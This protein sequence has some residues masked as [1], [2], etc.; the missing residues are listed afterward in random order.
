MKTAAE[1]G[2]LVRRCQ[3][4]QRAHA[5]ACRNRG[6]PSDR[7]G[8]VKRNARRFRR[9]WREFWKLAGDGKLAV[10]TL[11]QIP[12]EEFREPGYGHAY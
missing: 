6:W 7:Y 10:V 5:R 1:I 2:N 4:A 3:R 12:E 11:D 8:V 9:H